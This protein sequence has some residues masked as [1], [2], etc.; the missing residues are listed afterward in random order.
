MP[1]STDVFDLD[2]VDGIEIPPHVRARLDQQFA[3]M[4]DER[5]PA[6]DQGEEND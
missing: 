1:E 3:R 2:K 6:R 4:R 5:R